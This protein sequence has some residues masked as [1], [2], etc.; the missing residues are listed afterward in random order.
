MVSTAVPASGIADGLDFSDNIPGFSTAG[1]IHCQAALLTAANFAEFKSKIALCEEFGEFV[2]L[3]QSFSRVLPRGTMMLASKV[4]EEDERKRNAAIVA[5]SACSDAPAS[6]LTSEMLEKAY[7]SNV[8]YQQPKSRERLRKCFPEI[9][10]EALRVQLEFESKLDLI[11]NMLKEERPFS[12]K[13]LIQF[14]VRNIRGDLVAASPGD[15]SLFDFLVDADLRVNAEHRPPSLDFGQE[16]FYG[17][18]RPAQCQLQY[19]K[20][21]IRLEKVGRQDLIP[22]IVQADLSTRSTSYECITLRIPFGRAQSVDID[23]GGAL[24]Y[25]NEYDSTLYYDAMRVVRNYDPSSTVRYRDVWADVVLHLDE[26][27]FAWDFSLSYACSGRRRQS[28]TATTSSSSIGVRR[29]ACSLEPVTVCPASSSRAMLCSDTCYDRIRARHVDFTNKVVFTSAA[30]CVAAVKTISDL[31]S[32]F[33]TDEST[34]ASIDQTLI[35]RSPHYETT[36]TILSSPFREMR[37]VLD[38]GGEGWALS[39]GADFFPT[40]DMV[41]SSAY[42]AYHELGE[43]SD[44]LQYELFVNVPVVKDPESA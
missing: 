37:F 18:L 5:C 3:S 30:E 15:L 11:R 40:V 25:S 9:N 8:L 39:P 22:S 38:M 13:H 14:N 27:V 28:E 43:R 2:G 7:R 26:R 34:G 36:H 6:G 32:A 42:R 4:S 31:Q 29:L 23:F 33:A 21:C 20:L 44:V 1:I 12:V 17:A 19:E 35:N 24:T 16:V 10:H 41:N